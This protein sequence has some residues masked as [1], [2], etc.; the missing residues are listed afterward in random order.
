MSN[1]TGLPVWA[2]RSL[3]PDIRFAVEERIDLA[4][5]ALEEYDKKHPHDKR[6]PGMTRYAMPVNSLGQPIE[7]D[8]LTRHRFQVSAIQE[9]RVRL[10]TSAEEDQYD[11]DLEGYGETNP[12]SEGFDPSEYEG[13]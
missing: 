5:A 12:R 4:D 8:G 3:D 10:E 7:Y 13:G 1:S 9:T 6:K 11:D 2:T